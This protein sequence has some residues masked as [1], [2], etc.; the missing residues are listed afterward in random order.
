MSDARRDESLSLDVVGGGRSWRPHLKL[1]ERPLLLPLA[2]YPSLHAMSQPLSS[3]LQAF[4]HRHLRDEP[5]RQAAEL[6]RIARLHPSGFCRE[7]LALLTPL[8]LAAAQSAM[9][10][11]NVRMELTAVIRLAGLPWYRPKGTR[12]LT[13][14]VSRGDGAALLSAL[15]TIATLPSPDLLAA[16]GG[17]L[18]SLLE[19][20]LWP[21]DRGAQIERESTLAEL[22]RSGAPATIL[23]GFCALHAA[24]TDAT[25]IAFVDLLLVQARSSR[26]AC[27]QLVDAGVVNHMLHITRSPSRLGSAR[28]YSKS[29]PHTAPLTR[30]G[31]TEESEE[32]KEEPLDRIRPADLNAEIESSDA[33][34]DAISPPSS[35]PPMQEGCLTAYRFTS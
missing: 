10:Q 12:L 23:N 3:A 30:A 19:P 14:P 8:L 13:D 2:G 28:P 7:D 31:E 34:D 4:S 27:K 26:A 9:T 33:E 1:P 16:A 17:A 18:T 35:P 6:R 25:C 15:A 21:V 24:S 22:P 5:S 29:R 11:S 20:S 32:V